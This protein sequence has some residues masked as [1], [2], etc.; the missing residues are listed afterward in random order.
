MTSQPLIVLG[1]IQHLFGF[2]K[3]MLLPE[4]DGHSFK[5]CTF[6][7]CTLIYAG[8]DFAIAEK[9]FWEKCAYVFRGPAKATIKYLYSLG[10]IHPDR[11]QFVGQIVG[12]KPS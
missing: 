9:V 11:V 5:N 3:S 4:I 10:W 1:G 6:R 7:N 12:S 8:G 2:I